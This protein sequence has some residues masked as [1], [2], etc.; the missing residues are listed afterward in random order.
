MPTAV[1]RFTN[2]GPQALSKLIVT[3]YNKGENAEGKVIDLGELAAGA[4][5]EINDDRGWTFA[6]G[7]RLT[8]QA[9]GYAEQSLTLP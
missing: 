2:R 5:A 1:F 4:I 3:C 6:P 9:D 7:E 8:I